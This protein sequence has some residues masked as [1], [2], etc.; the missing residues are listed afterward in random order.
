MASKHTVPVNSI[1]Q[2]TCPQT[3]LCELA[4]LKFTKQTLYEVAIFLPFSFLSIF[5]TQMHIE[6]ECDHLR[7]SKVWVNI[8]YIIVS[9]SSILYLHLINLMISERINAKLVDFYLNKN[10]TKR[11]GKKQY[12]S[13]R[14]NL[15]SKY[16]KKG[17]NNY[18]Y[19][20][21]LDT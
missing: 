9:I 8:T 5:I 4:V 10:V 19:W 21:C 20:E 16:R 12:K 15:S 7:V 6:Y 14:S 3:I 13:K 18:L 2:N 1:F 17:T 11:L